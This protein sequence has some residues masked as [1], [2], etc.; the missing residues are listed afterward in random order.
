MKKKLLSLIALLLALSLFAGLVGCDQNATN[1]PSGDGETSGGGANDE[2]TPLAP[3]EG[4]KYDADEDDAEYSVVGIGE[5]VGVDIVIASVYKGKYVTSIG[6][7]AFKKCAAVKSV[8]IPASIESIGTEAFLECSELVNIYFGGTK[9]EWHAIKKEH[10]W[11]EGTAEF[12]VTCTDGSLSKAESEADTMPPDSTTIDGGRGEDGSWENVDFGG[13]QVRFAISTNQYDGGT[14]PAASIYTKG[15]D[16]A[17]VNEVTSKVLARNARAAQELNVNIFYIERDL[18]YFRVLDDVRDAVL[19]NSATSPD[20]YNNDLWGLS[21]AMYSGYLWNTKDPGVD[22]SGNAYVN[23]FDYEADGWYTEFI[24]SC[25]FDQ[26]KYYLFAGDYFIDMI[27][28]A[29]VIFVNNDVMNENKGSVAWLDNL[30]DF[31]ARVEAGR[32]DFD[33]LQKMSDAMKS[34]NVSGKTSKDDKVIGFSINNVTD[35]AIAPSAGASLFYLDEN[36]QPKVIE[37]IGTCQRIANK[38]KDMVGEK[39]NPRTGVFFESDP[40]DTLETFVQGNVLFASSL[41]GEMEAYALRNVDFAK[42]VAPLPKWSKTE[43][44][45]YHTT[46]HDQTEIGCILKSAH[47]YSAASALM[48]YLNEESDAVV[49]AYYEKGMKY[50]YT[51]DANSRMMMDIIRESTDD[52]FRTVVGP[53]CLQLYHEIGGVGILEGNNAHLMVDKTSTLSGIFASE[54]DAYKACLNAMVDKFASFE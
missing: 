41:L 9:E 1:P 27:R 38:Y 10:A 28:M 36:Y 3:T 4:L 24:K 2:T 42:G 50:K 13:Q 22:A 43:Q 15:P 44:D 19:S 14:F 5:A 7:Q 30:D 53:L 40:L 54:K 11:N 17:D 18:S 20:I 26:S 23:Y 48:Q 31:Y 45:A 49:E 6:K 29:W 35:W 33:M 21:R 52:S 39:D 12:T 47:A 25:T 51:T 46:V 37:D 8:T 34:G 32:W 16:M